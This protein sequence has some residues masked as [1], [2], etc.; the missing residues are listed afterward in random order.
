MKIIVFGSYDLSLV[1]FRGQLLSA[2]VARGYEVVALAPAETSGVPHA[3]KEMG[4]RY[5]PVALERTGLSFFSDCRSRQ[6]L[7]AIFY[8]ERPDIVLAYTIKPI[9]Y[10]VAIAAR[11]GVPLR[12][13]LI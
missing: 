12:Y 11:A 7:K 1:N 3:L 4:V 13:A 2:L 9:V 5:V 6:E 10:G 8:A